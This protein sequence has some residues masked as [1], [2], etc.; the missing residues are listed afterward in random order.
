M[1]K[2]KI[3]G[4]RLSANSNDYLNFRLKITATK[5]IRPKLRARNPRRLA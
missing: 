2:I 4:Q 3:G 1:L 5:M